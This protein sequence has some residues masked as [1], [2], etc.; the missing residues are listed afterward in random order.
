MS[1][2][3]NDGGQRINYEKGAMREPSEGKGA[4]ELMSPFAL[5]RIAKWYE[6]GAQKYASRNWEK[7]IPFGRLIQSGIRHMY[8]WMAGDR[9]E[10]HLAA[11]CW[12]VMAMMHFEATGQDKEWNDYPLY[13]KSE[14][15]KVGELYD[16]ARQT[17]LAY[18]A[19]K[20]DNVFM[21]KKLNIPDSSIS[22]HAITDDMLA[23]PKQIP[24]P[25]PICMHYDGTTRPTVLAVD[26]D[27]T[28]C[29]NAWPEIGE[30]NTALINKLIRFRKEGGELI[31]WTCREGDALDNAVEWCYERDLYFDAINE[32]LPDWT[33]LFGNNSRKV[34]ADWYIDDKADNRKA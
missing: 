31:L 27:G 23:K 30:P 12:N 10:D 5:E 3:M 2:K 19:D 29:T 18:S 9:S 11:V 16:K 1:D 17:L 22:C 25:N 7:G 4:Y 8:R 6:L 28:L 33:K 24:L 26:F 20:A 32:N 34:G 13:G 15:D 14:K 21:D